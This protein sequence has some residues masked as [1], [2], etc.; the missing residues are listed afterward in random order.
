MQR[1][2]KSA[3][4]LGHKFKLV[5]LPLELRISLLQVFLRVIARLDSHVV[6]VGASDHFLQFPELP[7]LSI[8]G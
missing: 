8:E 2:P 3:S 7:S 5:L 6:L 4:F 1:L